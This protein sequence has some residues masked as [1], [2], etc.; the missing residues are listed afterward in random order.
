MIGNVGRVKGSKKGFIALLC[1]PELYIFQDCNAK[2]FFCGAIVYGV[3]ML[4]RKQE[5]YGKDSE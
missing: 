5:F 4:L 1:N 2:P 3:C